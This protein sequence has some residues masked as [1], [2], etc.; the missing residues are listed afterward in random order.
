MSVSLHH[1]GHRPLRMAL[2]G[3]GGQAFIGRVHAV[4]AQ[5]DR[6]AELVAGA[7]SSDPERS[8]AAADSFGIAPERAYGSYDEL[9]RAESALPADQ[10]VHFVSIATPNH[11]HFAI[12]KAALEAG[13]HVVCDKPM[14]T[15]WEDAV[16]L[17]RLVQE[18][19]AVFAL[20]HNYTGYPLIRQARQMIA[21]GELGE[22]QAVRA[23]YIQGWLCGLPP[24]APNTRGKW[25]MDPERAGSGSLGDVG[26]HAFNLVCYVSGLTPQAVSAHLRTY[27]PQ[28]QLDDYGHVIVRMGPEPLALINF[29]QTTHGRLNDL[30]LEVDGSRASLAWR[31]EEPNQLIVRR[32]GQATQVYERQPSADYVNASAS[33]ACRL[34][35]GHPEG[36]FEA[37]AN[38]YCAAFDDM[39][40]R[41]RGASAESAAPYPN[42]N[43]GVAGVRFV[44]ACLASSEE[45]GTWKPLC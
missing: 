40:Q 34:P 29:S 6:R 19:G 14:T 41:D 39:I 1:P 24:N 3:G 45:Q 20:T 44:Q 4:A 13:F 12:A 18:T 26:T 7:L 16:E 43:D 11:T 2:I 9:L 38:V 35:G 30:T 15:R 8:R 27:Q 17:A 33:A 31:Q 21:D 28:R 10:R 42:V 22:I 5:L 23:N 37:F 25:K 32:T 36:F